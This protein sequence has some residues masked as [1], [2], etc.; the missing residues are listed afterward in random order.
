MNDSIPPEVRAAYR[1]PQAAQALSERQIPSLINL[2][3][4]VHRAC[5]DGV[6]PIVLQR[7]HPVFG[8]KVHLD[9]EAVTTHLVT[10]GLETPLLLRTEDNR[11]WVNERPPA[12]RVWRA[13]SYVAGETLH[14]TFEPRRLESAARLLA[15]FHAALADFDYAFE[16]VRRIHDTPRQLENLRLA[17][18]SERGQADSEARELGAAI[19]TQAEGIRVEFTGAPTRIIHGDPKLSNV[20]FHAGSEGAARCM[21]DLDTLGYGPLAHELGDV[22]RS[23]CNPAGEDSADPQISVESLRAV[24]VGYGAEL[25]AGFQP[26]EVLSALDGL[27]TISLELASRF[28]ADAIVDDY[29]GWDPT[30]F[31]SRRE[32]NLVRA[33]GQL[34]LSRNVRSTRP[35]L[36]RVARDALAQSQILATR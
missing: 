23:W 35:E 1:L 12:A 9:I 24:F 19:L 21:I 7:L 28:A 33:R 16:H 26:D 20:M 11:L 3:F 36:L 8:E 15:R 5:G 6:E 18:S 14:R 30:R 29:F 34:A 22:L 27:E 2:T 13:L 4:V 25:P 10:R 32:H 17:I 31:S